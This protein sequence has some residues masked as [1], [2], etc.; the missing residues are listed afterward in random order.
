M[1]KRKEIISEPEALTMELIQFVLQRGKRQSGG[2][3]RKEEGEK[4]SLKH[5]IERVS[6]N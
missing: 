2:G 6:K 4:K 5:R 1:E 3:E